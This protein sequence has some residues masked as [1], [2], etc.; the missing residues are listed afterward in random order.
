VGMALVSRNRRGRSAPQGPVRGPEAL[1]GEEVLRDGKLELPD[2][3]RRSAAC[4]S[5]ERGRTSAAWRTKKVRM[6]AAILAPQPQGGQK[7]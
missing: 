5:S 1:G 4:P 3:A 7:E 2:V 6:R